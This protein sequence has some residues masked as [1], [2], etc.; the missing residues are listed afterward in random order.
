MGRGRERQRENESEFEIQCGIPGNRNSC[1]LYIGRKGKGLII[2][3]CLKRPRNRDDRHCRQIGF[4]SEILFSV[5][6]KCVF[7][8]PQK[9]LVKS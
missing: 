3:N 6:M 7:N 4:F 8:F 9:F 1:A 2:G 5:Y